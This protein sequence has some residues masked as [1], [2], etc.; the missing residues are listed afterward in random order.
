MSDS[1]KIKFYTDE[2]MAEAVADQLSRRGVDIL[3][4]QSTGMMG[5]DDEEHL[6]F[7][8]S[9]GRVLV[10]QDTD[11]QSI[12][13][14]WIGAGKTHAGII[15][16]KDTLSIGKVISA[17]ELLYEYETSDQLKDRLL[18]ASAYV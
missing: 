9:R 7:A 2:N 11:F 3:R 18:F 16:V 17:L 1:L 5:A 14:Q 15:F 10:T 8:A 13:Y 6:E 12:H 4:C